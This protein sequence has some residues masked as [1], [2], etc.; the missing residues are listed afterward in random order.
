MATIHFVKT[1]Q[2]F[3]DAS[4]S[5]VKKFTVRLDDRPYAVGDILC[6]DCVDDMGNYTN[7]SCYFIITYKLEGGQYGIESGYCV[8]GIKPASKNEMCK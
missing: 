5:G 8:L 3:F 7:H 2:Q 4:Y 1:K 6:K